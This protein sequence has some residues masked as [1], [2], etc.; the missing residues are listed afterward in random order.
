MN[1][2]KMKYVYVGI[3]SHKDT[4]CAVLLNCFY[5]KLGEISFL[6]TPNAFPEFIDSIQKY[7]RGGTSFAFGLED[8]SAY[9]RSLT[10]FLTKRKYLVKHVNAALVAS[11]RKSRNILHKT[12]SEDAE[13]AARV[14]LS[15]FD[16]L[17]IA[18]P[19]DKFW[20]LTNLVTRRRMIVKMNIMLK[21]HLHSFLTAHYPSY[22]K[23]FCHIDSNTALIFFEKYPSPSKLKGVTCEELAELLEE[24]SNKRLRISKARQILDCVQNDGDTTTDYQESRDQA[25]RSTIS[26]I[27]SNM[28]ELDSIDA[29]LEEFLD[30]FDYKLTSMRG[31]DTVTAANLIAEIG[32]ISKFPTPAKLARY[33]GIAPVTYSSGQTNIQY[34]NQRGNRTLNSIFYKLSVIVTMTAGKNNK[35][36]NP[37][38]Y[39]YYHKKLREG[40]TKGQALKCVQRR[41]VN[42]IWSMMT[43][44]TE[45]I[46]PPT[47]DAPKE[48]KEKTS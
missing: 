13:C 27:N 12:D 37:F 10:V 33:A 11:E 22:S 36:I 35:I 44:K 7:K 42:I 30:R 4:H 21:N 31:I 28:K 26:Q 24:N 15:R 39:E 18:D 46:N 40:K 20:V 19:Q 25:V 23:F 17:P 2:P 3:D 1:H 48:P 47:F 9:G 29:I 32:D 34:A 14:L 45:Y 8:V 38:F 41:L 6:N 43:H 5:E 16:E